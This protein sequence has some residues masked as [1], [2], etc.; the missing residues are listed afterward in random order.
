MSKTIKLDDAVYDRL[1]AF[2][3]KHETKSQAVDRLLTVLE[4][5]GDMIDILEGRV[6]FEK[7]KRE[8]LEQQAPPL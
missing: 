7:G 3:A 4:K 1:D 8:R 6:S 2:Q 5:A